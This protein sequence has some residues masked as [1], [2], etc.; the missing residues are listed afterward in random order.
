V[1]NWTFGYTQYIRVKRQVDLRTAY[2]NTHIRFRSRVSFVFELR[3]FS[4]LNLGYETVILS[5]SWLLLVLPN[6][7][8]VTTASFQHQQKCILQRLSTPYRTYHLQ[9][10]Q[11]H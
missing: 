9:F 5:F 7:K 3:E 10:K 11:C 6:V 4:G 1:H 8:L 2:Q